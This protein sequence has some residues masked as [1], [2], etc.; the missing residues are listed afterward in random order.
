MRTLVVQSSNTFLQRQQTFI[1]LSTFEPPYSIVTLTI[2]SSL[3]TSQINHQEFTHS[4]LT[5]NHINLT[6]GMRSTR[7]IVCSC[8][9]GRPNTMT[10]IYNLLHLIRTIG[11]FLFQPK[12]LNFIVFVFQNLKFL[13]VIKQIHTFSTINLECRHH[14]FDTIM[15]FSEFEYIIYYVLCNLIYGKSLPW[16][17]LAVSKN[18]HNAVVKQTWEQVF[19][20]VLV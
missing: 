14:K 1:N 12:Y 20:W 4:L 3:R 15:F 9:M 18:G 6:N 19:D 13:F 8:L 17:G 10:I 11:N 16:S 2:C 7:S 5:N